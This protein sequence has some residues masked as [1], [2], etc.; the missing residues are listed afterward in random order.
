L[1][2]LIKLYGSNSLGSPNM[3]MNILFPL[4][5]FFH[6][7]P[8][9]CVGVSEYV[10]VTLSCLLDYNVK[11]LKMMKKM[12]RRRDTCEGEAWETM[13]IIIIYMILVY[14]TSSM[15][16]CFE[17]RKPV[18]KGLIYVLASEKYIKICYTDCSGVL[19]FFYLSSRY[20]KMRIFWKKLF[21]T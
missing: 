4:W 11:Q 10:G 12:W 6:I 7:H 19:P 1:S 18:V 20:Y 21:A 9:N 8:N 14:T 5:E 2:K 15:C 13:Y 17:P 16:M 3:H